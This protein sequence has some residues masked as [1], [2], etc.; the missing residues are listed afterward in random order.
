MKDQGRV[1]H[2]LLLEGPP[3]IGKLALARAFAQYIHCQNPTPDGDSCGEC[4]SCR[5][6]EAMTHLDLLF[7]FP[8][9]KPEKA[10]GYAVSDDFREEW[11]D[12]LRG[13][14]FM[15]FNEWASVF[16]KKNANPQIYVAESAALI[17]NLSLT[18]HI[19]DQKIVIL[20]L[21]EKLNLEA[22]NKIL[23]LVEEPYENTYF[24]MVSD[25]P[26]AI[27]PTIYSRVQRV[28]VSRLPDRIVADYLL[29]ENDVS[30]DDAMAAAHISE[31][32][33]TKA[34]EVLNQ[35]KDSQQYFDLFVSLMRLAYQRNVKELKLWSEKVADLGR[36]REGKFYENCIRL[37]RENFVY[38]LGEPRLNYMTSSESTFSSR[39]ARFITE[40]NVEKLIS[41]FEKAR[42]DIAGNGNGKIVNF[43]V[44]IKVII[45]L[46]PR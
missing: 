40:K 28:K 44:A 5:L 21:P 39:F 30:P 38:R 6:H 14:I 11:V 34:F 20:Y 35:S 31:G 4:K 7:V 26:E 41:V 27:L 45:L 32:I 42:T 10:S 8:V 18:S 29:R 19:S 1:P 25:K 36:E 22:A 23:K 37:M 12:F 3:G 33:M 2:A 43:D 46:V 24:I 13:R 15:D 16:S 9:V 17:R